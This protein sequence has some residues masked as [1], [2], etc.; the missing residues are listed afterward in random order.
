[1]LLRLPGPQGRQVSGPMVVRGTRCVLA[2]H[3]VHLLLRGSMKCPGGQGT[4]S[5]PEGRELRAH[6]RHSDDWPSRALLTVME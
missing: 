3:S 2:G 4:H 5:E 6:A 1:M